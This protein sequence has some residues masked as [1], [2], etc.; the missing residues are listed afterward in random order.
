MN[1]EFNIYIK[2]I[3]GENELYQC[4]SDSFDI[5]DLTYLTKP[6][7]NCEGKKSLFNNLFSLDG[8]YL[9]S[10]YLGYNSFLEIYID[11][12]VNQENEE[13]VIIP[14][15]YFS[16]RTFYNAAKYLKKDIIYSLGFMC[17]HLVKIDND[18]NTEVIIYDNNNYTVILNSTNP[19]RYLKGYGYKIKSNKNIM[20]YFYRKLLSNM[21]QVLIDKN[22][23]EKNIKIKIKETK[24]YSQYCFDIG[25][26]GYSS[27][28]LGLFSEHISSQ[29]NY[30]Y[31]ENIYSKIEKKLIEGE[32]LYF[33]YLGN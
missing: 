9:F 12:S 15:S 6:I 16:Q 32:S 10:G 5:N 19:V 4:K 23:K 20:I 28:N 29:G 26:K 13:G 30:I 3:F 11:Y 27:I 22:Y 8:N 7:L 24:E 14:L 1:N 21:K 2:N 25:F 33:Y 17:D 31:F 18:L